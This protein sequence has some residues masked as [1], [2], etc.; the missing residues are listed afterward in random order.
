MSCLHTPCFFRCPRTTVAPWGLSPSQSCSWGLS[1]NPT[2][3]CV[4]RIRVSQA[5]RRAAAPTLCLCWVS[6]CLK[7]T[8]DKEENRR[9]GETWL[10]K[11]GNCGRGEWRERWEGSAQTSLMQDTEGLCSA[12]HSEGL[13]DAGLQLELP[14]PPQGGMEAM[15]L[16]SL[17]L[18]LPVERPRCG[19]RHRHLP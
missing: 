19:A 4:T 8:Q 16:V 11:D 7:D 6:P 12:I 3:E 17:L 10:G 15:S 1:Q 5:S 18:S 2:F 9:N 14:V 13:L